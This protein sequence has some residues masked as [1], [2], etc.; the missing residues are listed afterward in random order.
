ML[1]SVIDTLCSQSKMVFSSTPLLARFG[2]FSFHQCMCVG[3]K[4]EVL[5]PCS[6]CDEGRRIC[7]IV[8]CALPDCGEG[9]QPYTPEGECCSRCPQPACPDVRG[10]IGTCDERCSEDRSCE[11]GQLCCSNGCGHACMVPS[12]NCSVSAAHIGCIALS[13]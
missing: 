8:D 10:L 13:G 3:V 6:S 5:L 7:A 1:A 4:L 11:D 9:L 2:E 12:V